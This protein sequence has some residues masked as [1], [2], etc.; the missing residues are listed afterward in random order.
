MKAW[1]ISIGI[2]GI[3]AGVAGLVTDRVIGGVMFLVL[4]I[5]VLLYARTLP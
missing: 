3:V 4:G 5:A 2:G 1:G